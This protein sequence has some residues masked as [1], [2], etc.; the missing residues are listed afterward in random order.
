MK[1]PSANFLGVSAVVL[2]AIVS[3]IGL[4]ARTSTTGRGYI[5]EYR[6]LRCR[7]GAVLHFAVVDEGRTKP[8]ATTGSRHSEK[9][10]RLSFPGIPARTKI[11]KEQ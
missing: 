2:V 11:E 10:R 9:R 8:V 1:H 4:Q 5:Q 3:A 7:G 6:E